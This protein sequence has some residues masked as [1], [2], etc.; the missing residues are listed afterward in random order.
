[1]DKKELLLKILYD[2]DKGNKCNAAT[3]EIDLQ[4]FGDVLEIAIDEGYVKGALFQRA[5]Q[6]NPVL[7]AMTDNAKITLAGL[8]YLERHN[9]EKL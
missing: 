7:Y 8:N 3:Y 1:M 6:G 5:G 9:I 2:I 4:L